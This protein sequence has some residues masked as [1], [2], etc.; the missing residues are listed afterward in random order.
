LELLPSLIKDFH[1]YELTTLKIMHSDQLHNLKGIE[2][3]I[4]LKFINLSSNNLNGSINLSHSLIESI[5]LSFNSITSINL[6][7]SLLKELILSNNN[8]SSLHFLKHL[9]LIE[10]LDISDNNIR[11]DQSLL[12]ISESKN[13]QS[14]IICGNPICVSNGF[15]NKLL[16]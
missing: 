14:L 6:S 15:I 1:I 11:D 7:T 2:D 12:H 8:I 16:N 4:N 10:K 5:N 9:D 3:C 13:L